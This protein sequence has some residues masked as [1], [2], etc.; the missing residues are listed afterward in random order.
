MMAAMERFHQVVRRMYI[1]SAICAIKFQADGKNK[2]IPFRL[3]FLML[4]DKSNRNVYV[5]AVFVECA[6]HKKQVAVFLNAK[7]E[8]AS[9]GYCN[10]S[11]KSI[12]KGFIIKCW[13]FSACACVPFRHCTAK[14]MLIFELPKYFKE[15]K[16]MDGNFFQVPPILSGSHLSGCFRSFRMCLIV[17]AAKLTI[18]IANSKTLVFFQTLKFK[19]FVH[20]HCHPHRTSC[21]G[22]V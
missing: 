14:V 15:K 3:I 6:I 12:L 16:S 5:A 10:L 20:V 7:R 4:L 21:R 1:H 2:H 19:L 18:I 9:G 8:R 17:H 13:L 22:T 11:Y